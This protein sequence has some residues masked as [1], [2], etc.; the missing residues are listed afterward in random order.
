MQIEYMTEYTG[1][2]EV[3]I[4][5]L[6]KNSKSFKKHRQEDERRHNTNKIILSID[7]LNRLKQYTS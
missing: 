5:A 7:N 3:G 1:F 4:K 2:T 6:H